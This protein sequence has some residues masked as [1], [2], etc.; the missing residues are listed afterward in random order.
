LI[1]DISLRSQRFGAGQFHYQYSYADEQD[2][3]LL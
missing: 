3:K 1:N 2:S